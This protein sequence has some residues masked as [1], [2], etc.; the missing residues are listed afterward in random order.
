MV[1]GNVHVI[2]LQGRMEQTTKSRIVH[3]VQAPVHGC[4]LIRIIYNILGINCPLKTIRLFIWLNIYLF[5]LWFPVDIIFLLRTRVHVT[6]F[7]SP[8]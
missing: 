2:L 7:R 6:Q 5:T 4:L 1:G 8:F 3:L